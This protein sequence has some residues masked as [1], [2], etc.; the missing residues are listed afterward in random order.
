MLYGKFKINGPE[1]R[2]SERMGSIIRVHLIATQSST[3]SEKSSIFNTLK[4]CK[5]PMQICTRR[6]CPSDT[7]C[8]RHW[9][10]ISRRSINLSLLSGSVPSTININ[11][12]HKLYMFAADKRKY[13]IHLI[14][15][16]P[17]T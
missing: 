10:S 17:S 2:H 11:K 3:V 5:R 4:G 7:L 9:R 12:G 15:I 6:R 8:I 1:I 16:E 13:C 14:E